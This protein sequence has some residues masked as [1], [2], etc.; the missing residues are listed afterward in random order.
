MSLLFWKVVAITT[1][2]SL[3]I[4]AEGGADMPFFP[5]VGACLVACLVVSPL[6]FAVVKASLR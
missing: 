6:I 3:F 5:Y 4:R 2:W 1:L